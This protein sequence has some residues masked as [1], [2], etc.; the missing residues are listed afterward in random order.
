MSSNTRS[1]GAV[2]SGVGV[3]GI[4]IGTGGVPRPFTLLAIWT[5]NLLLAGMGG[6]T[7]VSHPD[8]LVHQLEQGPHVR[9]ARCDDTHGGFNAGPHARIDLVVCW[10]SAQFGGFFVRG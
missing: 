4:P 3:E 7:D 5:E 2:T 1:D 10:E 6:R 9:Q 8:L